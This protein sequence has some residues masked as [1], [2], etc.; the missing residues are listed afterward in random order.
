MKLMGWPTG[1]APTSLAS[2]AN[3]LLLNY[4]Q[5]IIKKPS[6]LYLAGAK[7]IERLLLG[8]ES[9]ALPLHQAPS[10]DESYDNAVCCANIS[11]VDYTTNLTASIPGNWSRNL[12][13][14]NAAWLP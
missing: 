8:L 1:A 9:N 10:N 7:R 2:Q 6:Y 3:V 11:W 5:Q 14:F 4:G 13:G 12:V